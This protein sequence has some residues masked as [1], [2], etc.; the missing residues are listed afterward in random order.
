ML[1]RRVLSLQQSVPCAAG[2]NSNG[3]LDTP[4]TRKIRTVAREEVAN[5]MHLQ[6]NHPPQALSPVSQ[7]SWGYV[8]PLPCAAAEATT[9]TEEES[10]SPSPVPAPVR[11]AATVE[12]ADEN[13]EAEAKAKTETE[14]PLTAAELIARKVSHALHEA[15][16]YAENQPNSSATSYRRRRLQQHTRFP[17]NQR[18]FNETEMDRV[19]RIMLGSQ[20]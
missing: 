6:Q 18:R 13:E 17:D 10:A 19:S 4:G 15:D 14:R 5:A 2:S 3:G 7:E 12:A 11:E 9:K 8:P 1:P 20:L 16:A